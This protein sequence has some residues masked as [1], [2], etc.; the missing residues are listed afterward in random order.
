MCGRGT[1]SVNIPHPSLLKMGRSQK[2]NKFTK[3]TKYKTQ[4][5]NESVKF[6]NFKLDL[7]L[8]SNMIKRFHNS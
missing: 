6:L 4:H 1:G 8:K 5:N 3:M 7:S 2:L